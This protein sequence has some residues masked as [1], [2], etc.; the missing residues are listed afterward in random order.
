M[1]PPLVF[2]TF[3]GLGC[4]C[5]C[6]IKHLNE[7][8]AEKRNE[9]ASTTMSAVRAQCNFSLLRTNLLCIRGS[10]TL[11]MKVVDL[12]DIDFNFTK[13]EVKIK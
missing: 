5:N 13:E 6:F 7:M 9:L 11:K 8:L 1:F 2:S 12:I 4:E 3:D 10:R